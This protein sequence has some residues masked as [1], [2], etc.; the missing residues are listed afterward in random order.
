MPQPGLQH[1]RPDLLAAQ[2]P[3]NPQG[4]SG[5][6]QDGEELGAGQAPRAHA[7]VLVLHTGDGIQ[8]APP[9][10]PQEVCVNAILRVW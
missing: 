10:R 4:V 6:R 1:S 7:L 3:A 9:P 2:R 5:P 8:D